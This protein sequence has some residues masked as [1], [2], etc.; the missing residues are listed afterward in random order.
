[1]QEAL[2]LLEPCCRPDELADAL[3][4]AQAHFRASLL[5]RMQRYAAQTAPLCVRLDVAMLLRRPG[6]LEAC[7][8]WLLRHGG[9]RRVEVLPPTPGARHMPTPAQ[10]VLLGQLLTELRGGARAAPVE[11][12]AVRASALG[13]HFDAGK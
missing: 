2:A 5:G 11:E 10:V 12:L 8:G 7:L 13:Q 1:M 6:R 3:E 4:A 9:L